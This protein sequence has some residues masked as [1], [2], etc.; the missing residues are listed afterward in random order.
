MWTFTDL[1]NYRTLILGEVRTGKTKL[2]QK[3]L[4]EAETLEK[5]IAVIDMAPESRDGVGGKLIPAATTAYYTTDI[6]TPRLTGKTEKEMEQLAALN[7]NRIEDLF[8]QYL[9]KPVLFMN[10]VSIYLQRGTVDALV[11]IMS[12]SRTCIMNGYFGTSLGEDVFSIKEKKK[13][14]KLQPFCDKIIWR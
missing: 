8:N 14:M 1:E 13:M 7:K 6:V 5:D 3:L 9:P 11:L 10:D 4:E 12:S 2:T